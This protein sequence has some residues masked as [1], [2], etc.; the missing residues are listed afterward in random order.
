MPEEKSEKEM[1]ELSKAIV[2]AITNSPKVRKAVEKICD[3]DD[4]GSNAYMMMM[5]EI[6]NLADFMGIDAPE[7]LASAEEACEE[8]DIDAPPL[9]AGDNKKPVKIGEGESLSEN[10]LAFREFMAERFDE[11]DWLSKNKIFYKR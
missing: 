1:D 6:K 7:D 9:A 3:T 10:E 11:A 5:L 2:A 8:A 4:L